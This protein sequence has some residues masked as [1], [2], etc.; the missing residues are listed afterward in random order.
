MIR[1]RLRHEVYVTKHVYGYPWCKE[2]IFWNKGD[3]YTVTLKD[4]DRVSVLL[5]KACE[6]GYIDFSKEEVTDISMK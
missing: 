5:S 1:I 2:I 6:L 4:S 3:Q